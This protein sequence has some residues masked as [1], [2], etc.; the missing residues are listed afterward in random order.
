MKT[1]PQPSRRSLSNN[2]DVRRSFQKD[3]SGRKLVLKSFFVQLLFSELIIW[4]SGVQQLQPSASLQERFDT[5]VHIRFCRE[6][7][8]CTWLQGCSTNDGAEMSSWRCR[9]SR[10]QARVMASKIDAMG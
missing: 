6:V 4:R 3:W 2:C 7:A 8:E 5:V 1:E 10:P 9:G